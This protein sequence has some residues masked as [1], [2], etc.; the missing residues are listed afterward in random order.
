MF[1]VAMRGL[2]AHKLRLLLTSLSIALGVAFVAG[3]FVLTDSMNT[4]LSKGYQDQYSGVDAVVRAPAA[5]ADSEAT[6]QRQPLAAS[7]LATVKGTP[8]VASA[9]GSVSGYALL[10]DKH[11]KAITREG[12]QTDGLSVHVDPA[13]AGK[14]TVATGRMPQQAGEVAIDAGTAKSA[15]YKV[16][17]KIGIS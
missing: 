1:R 14:T 6:D 10:T 7:V 8:G 4:S 12:A 5:F 16:G 3:T 11:G 2:T 17:D 9:E 13:L 15:G